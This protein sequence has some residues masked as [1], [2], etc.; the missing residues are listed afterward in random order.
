MGTKIKGNPSKFYICL[1]E[2][3]GKHPVHFSLPSVNRA[4]NHSGTL[5]SQIPSFYHGANCQ[6]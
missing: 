2:T 4:M 3:S 1:L 5:L 6:V